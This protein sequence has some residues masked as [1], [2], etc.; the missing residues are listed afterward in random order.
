MVLIDRNVKMT[1]F[2]N[3]SGPSSDDGGGQALPGATS[4]TKVTLYSPPREP[5][6]SPDR[7]MSL[8][9]LS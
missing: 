6:I 7:N 3:V 9:L 8:Y 1:V 4:Q 2:R 5:E